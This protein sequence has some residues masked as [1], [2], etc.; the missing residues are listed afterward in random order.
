LLSGK[1]FVGCPLS[2]EEEWIDTSIK[3]TINVA[4]VRGA[5]QKYPEWMRSF[6]VPFLSEIR[7]LKRFKAHGG[8]LIKPTLEPCLA[9]GGKEKVYVEDSQDQ[10]GTFLSWVFGQMDE[11]SRRDPAVMI[12]YQMS[13]KSPLWVHR[14]LRSDNPSKF[15][16][17][18]HNNRRK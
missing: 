9:K 15:C 10:Q 8:E 14:G 1:T 17:N 16:L 6:V 11:T 5:V 2:R 12:N 13:C 18:S 4:G 3:Y 7:N